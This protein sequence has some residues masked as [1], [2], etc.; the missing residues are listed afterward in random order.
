QSVGL[1]T[2]RDDMTHATAVGRPT[3]GYATQTFPNSARECRHNDAQFGHEVALDSRRYANG[4]YHTDARDI[5]GELLFRP[6][7]DLRAQARRRT[8]PRV[9]PSGRGRAAVTDRTGARQHVPRGRRRD[10]ATGTRRL[11]TRR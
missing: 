1:P 7:L 8:G 4:R 6:G 10:R 9:A 3:I 5:D 2:D 11:R